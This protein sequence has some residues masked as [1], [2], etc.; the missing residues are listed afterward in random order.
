MSDAKP[1]LAHSAIELEIARLSRSPTPSAD[2]SFIMGMIEMAC[3]L[4]QVSQAKGESYRE[5]LA[6]KAGDRI[7]ALRRAA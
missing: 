4:D 2:R 6:I 3:L 7:E 1:D 5:Q